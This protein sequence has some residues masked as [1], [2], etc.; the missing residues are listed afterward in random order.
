MIS[1]ARQPLAVV[2]VVGLVATPAMASPATVT[3]DA[4]DPDGQP[5]SETSTESGTLVGA[6]I[7]GPTLPGG[8]AFGALLVLALGAGLG[9]VWQ[10]DLPS[11]PVVSDGSGRSESQSVDTTDAATAATGAAGDTTAGD[12]RSAITGAFETAGVDV[13]DVW[14]TQNGCAVKYWT[15]ATDAKSVDEEVRTL[16]KSYLTAVDEGAEIQRLDATL[17]RN[18]EPFGTWHIREAWI[19]QLAERDMSPEAFE[20]LVFETVSWMD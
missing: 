11:T 13:I 18:A 10:R 3:F 7:S 15:E 6:A 1:R 9:T 2:V 4:P 17:V 19:H 8:V 5:R 16:T 20:Q 14:T 12:D